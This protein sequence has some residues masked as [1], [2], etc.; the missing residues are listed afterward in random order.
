ME[1]KGG[2]SRAIGVVRDEM[3]EIG[4]PPTAAGQFGRA[5]NP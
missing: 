2:G 5:D 3:C 4:M 1:D